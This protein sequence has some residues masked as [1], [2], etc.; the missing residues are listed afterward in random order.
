MGRRPWSECYSSPRS[1]ASRRSGRPF[2]SCVMVRALPCHRRPCAVR[3]T[4]K[5]LPSETIAYDEPPGATNS[6][7]RP[8]N[9][10][11]PIATRAWPD[12]WA[13]CLATR[14]RSSW[15]S[16]WSRLCTFG[17]MPSSRRT[18]RREESIDAALDTRHPL[19]HR[20]PRRASFAREVAGAV[21]RGSKP[22][23]DAMSA[24]QGSVPNCPAGRLVRLGETRRVAQAKPRGLHRSDQRAHGMHARGREG[25]DA[26]L[27]AHDRHV[28]LVCTTHRAK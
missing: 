4:T 6:R 7:A 22:P 9:P 8:R 10:F 11:D 27:R 19:H 25:N 28:P 24:M 13:N 20:R 14:S 23:R 5:L 15:K 21:A 18:W 16:L 26:T 2:A 3:T 12:C 17:S 1:G